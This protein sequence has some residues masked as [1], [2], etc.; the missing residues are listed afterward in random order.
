MMRELLILRHGKS[1]SPA[2]MDDFDRLLQKRGSE[3]ATRIGGWLRDR[4]LVPERVV[5]SPAARAIATAR[6]VCEATGIET[7]DIEENLDLYLAGL[8]TLLRILR[9]VPPEAQRV[10]IVGHNPGLE[11]LLASL[12][13][14]SV[15]PYDD[16][17][18]MPT[19]ALALLQMRN[20]WADTAPGTTSIIKL[21][22]PRDLSPTD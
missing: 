21:I 6:R 11:E 5:S 14:T 8:E 3:A 22:R 15:S 1:D 16:T 9:A 13:D 4:N 12:A 19:A 20:P 10:M 17:G 18:R 7:A 2:G